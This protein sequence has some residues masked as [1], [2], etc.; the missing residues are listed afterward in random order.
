MI[1]IIGFD[2]V[3]DLTDNI[4]NEAENDV[5]VSVIAKYENAKDIIKELMFYDATVIDSIEL[6]SPDADG[7]VDEYI[8]D[9]CYRDGEVLIGCEPIKRN[10]EYL[11]CEGDMLYILGDC[12]ERI[13][14]HCCYDK[15]FIAIIGDD[16]CDCGDDDNAK[17]SCGHNKNDEF[18]VD[19]KCNLDANDAL[20]IIDKMDKSIDR[21]EN[22]FRKMSSV[23]HF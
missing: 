6:F 15:A 21:M 10:G 20:E 23:F 8:I 18:H 11:N 13:L 14:D 7:Y 16:E 17:C 12:R 9:I 5:F 19:I 2:Y 22:M 3:E 1:D 4:I